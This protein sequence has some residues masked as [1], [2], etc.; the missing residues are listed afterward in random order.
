M[1][2]PG[3]KLI[4]ISGPPD[5]V[6]AQEKGLAWPLKMVIGLLSFGVRRKAKQLRVDYSFLFMRADGNQLSK[7][8]ALIDAG[9]IHPVIDK[10]FPFRTNRRGIGLCGEWA[11]KRKG[12]HQD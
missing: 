10:I 1:L 2:K 9:A 11:C 3:G 7:I 5:L 12:H 4:S 6:Y 8:V